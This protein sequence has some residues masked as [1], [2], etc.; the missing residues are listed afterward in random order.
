MYFIRDTF[1]KYTLAHIWNLQQMNHKQNPH[2]MKQGAWFSHMV[3]ALATRS[4]RISLM[5][6]IAMDLVKTIEDDDEVS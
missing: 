3:L 5:S 4:D 6:P 1:H 2:E